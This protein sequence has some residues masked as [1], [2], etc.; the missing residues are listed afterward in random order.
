MVVVVEVPPACGSH[1]WIQSG[2][3]AMLPK[4]VG[5]ASK[6]TAPGRATA[7][8]KLSAYQVPECC[9]YLPACR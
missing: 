6:V 5:E 8:L 3:S 1:L 2:A 9:L 7:A 4:V